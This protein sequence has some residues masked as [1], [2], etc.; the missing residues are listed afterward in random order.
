VRG[1]KAG[2]AGFPERDSELERVS[3]A[4]LRRF[5]R[6]RLAMDRTT[7]L[8]ELAFAVTGITFSSATY[9]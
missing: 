5:S 4:W 1:E 2:G 3:K 6:V 9:A 8:L 7:M